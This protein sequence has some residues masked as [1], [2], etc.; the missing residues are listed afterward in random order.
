MEITRQQ[1]ENLLGR[2]SA[3]PNLFDVLGSLGIYGSSAFLEA[4]LIS[5][6]NISLEYLG[7]NFE[8]FLEKLATY[9]SIVPE[10][11]FESIN[12]LNYQHPFHPV[13]MK[14]AYAIAEPFLLRKLV[15]EE[16]LEMLLKIWKINKI[17]V[18][19]IGCG[20]IMESFHKQKFSQ[21]R[22]GCK[23]HGVD[24]S[25]PCLNFCRFLSEKI[26]LPATLQEADLDDYSFEEKF[27]LVEISEVL[28][29]IRFPEQF[30]KKAATAGKL[31]L[32][33]IPIMLDNPDHIHVFDL[34]SISGLLNDA[35]LDVLYESVR[36]S[37]F[38][39]QYFYCAILKNKDQNLPVP[40]YPS[41]G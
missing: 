11:S 40:R 10:K 12:V 21:L 20:E 7:V 33:T 41:A 26:S 36:M 15:K 28:E 37:F 35:N 16:L 9:H 3:E 27:E 17:F 1:V 38:V 34:K 24:I 39:R 8:E 22:R 4:R 25:R 18:A 31:F 30:I 32:I 5:A 23:I 6:I 2:L 29:H 14:I 19:G 13:M